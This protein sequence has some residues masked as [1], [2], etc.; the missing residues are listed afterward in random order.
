MFS[1]KLNYRIINITALLLLL[2]IGVS[3]VEVWIDIFGKIISVTAPF[4]IGFAFAYAFTPM[5]NWLEKKG[6]KKYLAV[7]LV[8]VGLVLIV[9]GLLVVTLPL[10]YDQLTLLV[11][12]VVEVFDNIGAKFDINLGAFEIK[13]EDYLND[14]VQSIGVLASTLVL[15]MNNQD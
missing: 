4:I 15:P 5:I 9:V 12:M 8:V 7:T 10:V 6:L 3:N 2:Y 11:K 14:I 1:N 13:V